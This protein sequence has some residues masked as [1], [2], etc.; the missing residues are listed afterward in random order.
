MQTLNDKIIELRKNKW[1][2]GQIAAQL[3]ISITDVCIVIYNQ[4][5]KDKKGD[6]K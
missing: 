2:I 1:E 6:I 5:N 4:N 3:K